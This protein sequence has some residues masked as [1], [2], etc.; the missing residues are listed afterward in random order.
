M[1]QAIAN[2]GDTV[3]LTPL[4]CISYQKIISFKYPGNNVEVCSS[5]GHACFYV[6]EFHK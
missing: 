2:C 1:L 3:T 5:E 4:H 6:V